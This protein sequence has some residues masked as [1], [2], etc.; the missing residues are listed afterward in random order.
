MKHK[1][2]PYWM[3]PIIALL[4]VPCFVI[5]HFSKSTWFC[6]FWHFHKPTNLTFSEGCVNGKC[7]RCGSKIKINEEYNWDIIE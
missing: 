5:H 1:I 2:H 4:Y 7:K 6:S 3:F